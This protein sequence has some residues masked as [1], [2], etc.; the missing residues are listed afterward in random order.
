MEKSSVLELRVRPRQRTPGT[1]L[2]REGGSAMEDRE[3]VELYWRRSEEAIQASQR[4][5]GGY[6]TAIARNILL[7]FQDA[8][9]CLNDTWIGAWNAIPPHRP[10]RLRL[11]LGKITRV[12]ACDALR[13]R[14]ARKRGAGQVPA[15][16]EELSECVS[17][18][19]N[20]EE[21]VEAREL[22]ELVNRFL[23]TLPERDCNLF[24]RRYWYAEPLEA[25][26]ERYGL[27]VNTVK[28]SLFR[29]RKKLKAYL[30]KEGVVL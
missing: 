24:L 26:A 18:A 9:E 1:Q 6:C 5:Y 7:N 29:T 8:E 14:N 30:E 20:L 27:K 28:T 10:V 25:A 11:F 23:H 4:K 13:A 21:A 15:A 19:G 12:L 3:I 2:P 22:E 17:A 16:L